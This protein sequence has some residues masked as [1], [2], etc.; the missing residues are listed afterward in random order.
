MLIHLKLY[1]DLINIIILE[2]YIDKFND[3]RINDNIY[4]TIKIL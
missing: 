2:Y 4:D 3:E 1:I